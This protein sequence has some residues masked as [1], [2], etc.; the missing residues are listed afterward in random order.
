MR[1]W[2]IEEI[3]CKTLLQKCGPGFADYTL[4][5][6]EGCGFGCCYCYVPALRHYRKQEN[7][8]PWG[9]FVRVKTNAADVLRRE[10]LRIPS[11]VRIAIGTATDPWQP[12][13]KQYRITRAILEELLYYPNPISITTRSPLLIRDIPLL[14]RMP[15]VRVNLSIPTFDEQVRRA[16]EPMAPA[17]LGRVTAVL[18][19]QAA[20]VPYFVFM[21]PI[22]PGAMDNKYAIEDYFRQ[23]AAYGIREVMCDS[24]RHLEVFRADYEKRLAEY[25]RVSGYDGRRLPRARLLECIASAARRY[26]VTVYLPEE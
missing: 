11:E 22:L 17:V 1:S 21:C 26:G 19:L 15:R 8:A 3:E 20:G 12:V 18:A 14:K 2:I 6:Y 23:A 9:R 5:P 4:N 10:M 24:L 13:E 16:F 7:P 25:L